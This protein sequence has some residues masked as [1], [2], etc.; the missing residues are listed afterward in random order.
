MAEHSQSDLFDVGARNRPKPLRFKRDV[1]VWTA[2][3]AKLIE[4]YLTGFLYVTKH[5]TYIDGF[6]GPQE[7][8]ADAANWAARRALHMTPQWLR[9]FVLIE[10][11]SERVGFINEMLRRLPRT[12]VG[13]KMRDIKVLQ[14][15][16]N[17][18]LPRRLEDYP[19][20][21]SEATFCLLDQWTCQ[22]HWATVE[23]VA[24]HKKRGFKIELFYFLAN[25]WLLRSLKTTTRNI[26]GLDAW[27]GGDGWKVLTRLGSY[28]RA[29]LM[30]ERFRQELGYEFVTPYP[31]YN[32][33]GGKR[34]MFFM[35]HATDHPAAPV[36]MRS[37]YQRTVEPIPDQA[38]LRN[39]IEQLPEAMRTW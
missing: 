4:R 13:K 35:I 11:N 37:A 2:N 29:E 28:E 19:I 36:L 30:S 18:V 17:I 1:C 15:D 23:T 20:K 5:G 7:G 31:I 34:I 24:R 9:H 8:H 6:A 16:V 27:W 33:Y 25:S 22:C 39:E 21:S 3:K 26:D 12:P 38:S 10:E 14:G 32:H